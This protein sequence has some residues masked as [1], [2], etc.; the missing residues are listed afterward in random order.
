LTIW[1]ESWQLSYKYGCAALQ[2]VDQLVVTSRWCN[3]GLGNRVIRHIYVVVW[4][5]LGT[6]I[7]IHIHIWITQIYYY[8][9]LNI[10]FCVWLLSIMYNFS[11]PNKK[12]TWFSCLITRLPNPKLHANLSVACFVLWFQF[13]TLSIIPCGTDVN[14]G[15]FIGS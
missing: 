1:K 7:Y 8:I 14:N 12:Q 3:F 15:L 2:N 5:I 9:F 4:F 10:S 11:F 6:G 13:L